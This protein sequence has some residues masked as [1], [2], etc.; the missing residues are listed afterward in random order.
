[1]NGETRRRDCG[2]LAAGIAC[3]AILLA[4]LAAGSHWDRSAKTDATSPL[5]KTRASSAS[6]AHSPS[7]TA[8]LSPANS[9]STKLARAPE[10]SASEIP[11]A[12]ASPATISPTARARAMKVFGGLPMMFEA[13]QGQTDPRVKFLSRAPGYTLFLTDQEA[14]LSLPDG[15]P[16]GAPAHA[17]PHT[18]GNPAPQPEK[19]NVPKLTRIVRLKFAGG[20]TPKAFEGRDELPGKTNYFLGNDPAQWR[21]NVANYE[22][23]E[24]RGVYSG[25]DVVFHGNQQ[26]LEYD[27][28]V[29]PGADPHAIALDVEGAKRMRIT[30]RGDLVMGVGQSEL[31]MLK[32]VVYQELAGQRREVA[33]NFVLRGPHRIGFA[34]G[35]YDDS[36]P[37]VIDPTL[38]YSTYLGKVYLDSGSPAF[39]SVAVDDSGIAYIAGTTLYSSPGFLT[40]PSQTCPGFCTNPVAFVMK[41]N[42]AL[43]ETSQLAYST[44]LGPNNSQSGYDTRANAIAVDS[45]GNAYVAGQTNAANFPVLGGPTVPACGFQLLGTGNLPPSGKYCAFVAEVNGSSAS[46]PGLVYSTYIGGSDASGGSTANNVATG[47]SVDSAG[48]AYVTGYTTS[49]SLLT[50]VSSN[51]GQSLPSGFQATLQGAQNAF[52]AELQVGSSGAYFSYL[53]Y[54]GGNALDMSKGIAVSPNGEAFVVGATTSTNFPTLNAYQ[55]SLIGPNTLP[56]LNSNAFFSA[57]AKGGASLVY[58]TFLGG[59]GTDVANAVAASSDNKAYITG[60][61]GLSGNSQFEFPVTVN[62]ACS[63]VVS[64]DCPLM[65][66][67]KLDPSMDGTDSLIYSSYLGG[68]TPPSAGI[69]SAQGIAVDSNGD[70]FITGWEDSAEDTNFPLTNIPVSTGAVQQTDPCIPLGNL[71]TYLHE[72]S[73]GFLVEFSP[74]ATSVLYSTFLGTPATEGMSGT[75]IFPN[76][77]PIVQG[78][79]IALDSQGDAYISGLA[80]G[81]AN[82]STS[83]P[84]SMIPTTSGA[85]MQNPS[86]EF[87]GNSD[88]N[89]FL[90][91]IGGLVISP[92]AAPVI[93]PNG[94]TF[95]SPQTVTMTDATG[96]ANI[97]FTTDG[98]MPTVSSPVYNGTITVSTSETI[99]AIATASGFTQSGVATSV[100]TITVPPPSPQISS[101]T[102]N[103]GLQGQQALSVTIAGANFVAGSTSVTFG[104]GTAGITVVP[105]S[106]VVTPTSITATLN[107]AQSTLAG[108]YDVVVT[109]TGEPPPATLTS[110]FTVAVPVLTDNETITVTDSPFIVAVNP[111]IS[112]TAPVAYFSP[113]TLGFNDQ[114]GS[115]LVQISNIGTGSTANLII[116]NAPTISGSGSS[117]FAISPPTCTTNAT[118]FPITLPSDGACTF[119]VSYTVPTSG[120]ASATLTFN[121]NSALSNITTTGSNPNFTQVISLNGSGPSSTGPEPSATVTIP[122]VNEIIMV[123]DAPSASSGCGTIVI[124][125]SGTL[126]AA[127]GFPYSQ[128]F[129]ASGGVGAITWSLTGAPSWLSLNSVSGVLSGTPPRMTSKPYSLTV[130][131]IDAN[132]CSGT[133]AVSFSVV[134]PSVKIVAVSSDPYTITT[135]PNLYLATVTV[136]NAGNVPIS[137]LTITGA[138]LGRARATLIG[139]PTASTLAPGATT[140]FTAAFPATAGKAGT[141]VTLTFDGSY[142]AGNVKGALHLTFV[143]VLL[144]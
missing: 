8:P 67:A 33:G 30:P 115:Q 89:A 9:H 48:D 75:T 105:T 94:G 28:I 51:N 92:A 102:P 96:G 65:F 117:A 36:Q 57:V 80:G 64:G 53:S 32:P 132:T 35:P 85:F 113:S 79:G 97:Y 130:T 13:N 37:L 122:T 123:T 55:S 38:T 82:T 16:V 46:G 66:V 3:G 114:T 74:D 137:A 119:T 84:T 118:S 76:N 116:N 104:G 103:V 73:A 43:P 45:N 110:G 95:T 108:N 40:S 49:P 54:L 27:F 22:R 139:S 31:A 127:E 12:Q 7:A 14:V 133:A 56:V 19:S 47:I 99:N 68:N 23:V 24:Y 34:L 59:T 126:S 70:A 50:S 83:P 41:L 125:P 87:T 121:D 129:T 63:N 2:R 124:S 120:P 86:D 17:A 78:T 106:M 109:V 135:A 18:G 90:S 60:N 136:I 4:G 101:V 131:A 26:R 11:F 98:T 88:R 15:S 134:A 138:T 111:P 52:V 142:S 71:P 39:V 25:V 69:E 91:V 6:A 62:M 1:M 58:S 93:S 81:E 140:S 144:P 5:E 44:Y 29:A 100:F 141:L 128:I 112:V 20:N 143:G 77:F 61:S 42:P 10:S 107:I 21:K 72:C